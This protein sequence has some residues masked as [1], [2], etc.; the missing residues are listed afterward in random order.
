MKKIFLFILIAMQTNNL[1]ASHQAGG[2][3]TWTCQGT[4]YVF[5]V[6]YYRDCNG[7]P[8]PSLV[9]LT[10]TVP[11]VPAI[12]CNLI[13]QIDI[14]P[15]GTSGSGN[16]P[17]PTCAGAAGNPG[18]VEELNYQSA[19]ITLPGTPP[20]GGWA[21][22]YGDCCRSSALSNISAG[23]SWGYALRAK[24]Y[25][26]TGFVAGQCTDASPF[27]AEKPSVLLCTDYPVNYNNNAVD[28][29]LDSLIYSWDSPIED[30]PYP[31]TPAIPFC[32]GYSVNSQFPGTPTLNIHS[33]E[34]TYT[35]LMGGYFTTVVKVSAYKCN[36]LA[37]EIWRDVNITL[38]NGC[39]IPVAGNPLNNPPLITPPFTGPGGPN[40]VYERTV[41]AGDSVEFTLPA[42]DFDI[43]PP[44]NLQTLTLNA[45]GTQFGTGF[46]SATGGCP[47]P[48]CATLTPA[49]PVN[50][51]GGLQVNFKWVTSVVHLICDPTY[52]FYF[53]TKD[54]YC[55]AP[56]INDR[57]VAITVLPPNCST[58][59]LNATSGTLP[60]VTIYP[61]P[62]GEKLIVKTNNSELSEIVL[63]DM[64]SR[65]LLQQQFK[66]AVSFNTEH[67]ERGIYLYEVRGKNGVLKKGK[68][69]KE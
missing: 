64:V 49:P 51:P 26:F 39:T 41:C 52:Y 69:V 2:E 59:G 38:I 28:P 31:W 53:N 34:I 6:K 63:F 24:M 37:S 27:L 40:T 54:N 46:T 50:S 5:H 33:G 3:I 30:V 62:V 18:A 7:I 45:S 35:P 19:I 66:N 8:G 17:C 13:N 55:S 32:C 47:L 10:T 20:A 61:N 1:F 65:K 15:T 11:G 23:G 56:A 14:S 48:P 44:A 42:S 4:S 60:I 36:V 68:V 21:F 43:F 57:A 67:L 9:S 16:A 25:P 29:E 58:T 12:L 22:W